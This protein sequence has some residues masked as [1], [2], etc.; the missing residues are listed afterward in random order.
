MVHIFFLATTGRLEV[1]MGTLGAVAVLLI[2]NGASA[3][4]H[5]KRPK[6]HTSRAGGAASRT[7]ATVSEISARS[8]GVFNFCA[9]FSNIVA[10][11]VCGSMD[12]DE[13]VVITAI[14][15]SVCCKG[16]FIGFVYRCRCGSLC[17]RSNFGFGCRGFCFPRC[18]FD[19][20]DSFGPLTIFRSS[21]SCFFCRGFGRGFGFT[22]RDTIT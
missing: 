17:G 16:P 20:D 5:D 10:I 2:V 7:E 19:F 6:D 15:A 11:R 3:T 4:C 14:V 1:E 13:V 22:I 12:L 8:A 18:R 9:E 21:F